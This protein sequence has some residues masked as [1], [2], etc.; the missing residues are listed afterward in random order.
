MFYW[1]WVSIESFGADFEKGFPLTKFA[2]ASLFL[3]YLWLALVWLFSVAC[4]IAGSFILR[5]RLATSSETR[6]LVIRQNLWYVLSLGLETSVVILVWIIQLSLISVHQPETRISE[7][8]PF[9]FTYVD[10]GLAITF[11]VFHSFRGTIDLIVWKFALEISYSDIKD[12]VKRLRDK[13]RK[14]VCSI[15]RKSLKTPLLASKSGDSQVNKALRRNAMYCINIGILDAVQLHL[16]YI[17]KIKRVGSV[18]DRFV[19]D[20][21]IKLDEENQEQKREELYKE[22]PSRKERSIRRLQFPATATIQSFS[23]VDLEP[24]IFSQL[25]TTFG[26]T[27]KKYRES[28]KIRNAADIDKEGMLEKF[29]EGKSGSFFY[30][31]R[32]FRYIIKT[33]TTQE[34]KFLQKIAYK[35]YNHMQNNPDSLIARFYGLHKV[36]L[37]PEQRYITVVVMDNIFH[38]KEHLNMHERYDLKGSWVGRR[39]IKGSRERN[40]YKG[41]LKDLDL[42]DKKIWIGTENKQIL[43][44]QL[45]EDAQFLASCDIMDYSMLLGIHNHSK[46]GERSMGHPEEH[47]VAGTVGEDFIDVSIKVRPRAPQPPPARTMSSGYGT[48]T[49]EPEI[50]PVRTGARNTLKRLTIEENETTLT[51][52][53]QLIGVPWFREDYGGLRSCSPMHP[54]C[55]ELEIAPSTLLRGDPPVATYYFGIIDILQ[56]YNL[57][58]KLEHQ[59]KTKVQCQDKYGL[60]AVNPRD[61]AQRFGDFMEQIFV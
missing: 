1:C 26:I 10:F 46:F 33:V 29:T 61:Y 19:A 36:K 25:R 8:Q 53:T 45:K 6:R 18:R 13:N 4:V 60:S 14:D 17:G 57:R 34:E 43:I 9:F 15:S 12:L 20:Q 37:A 7:Q 27:P 22:D 21:M 38:N 39:S 24:S 23:F 48:D 11:A 44:S 32:D 58:K 30:F 3:Y 56:E 50:R 2:V 41:T 35:Y 59:W 54:R 49:R 51:S 31:T 40:A 16:Q 55:S 5:R 47:N 28:F 52:T 42:G